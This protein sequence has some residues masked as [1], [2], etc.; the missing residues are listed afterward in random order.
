MGLAAVEDTTV[1]LPTMSK[2]WITD[3]KDAGNFQP[4][5]FDTYVSSQANANAVAGA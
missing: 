3:P 5:V 4:P 2:G 1:I